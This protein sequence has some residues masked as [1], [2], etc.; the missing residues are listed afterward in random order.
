M[1][2]ESATG[3][4]TA[5]TDMIRAARTARAVEGP[6]LTAMSTAVAIAAAMTSL[7][8]M[9]PRRNQSVLATDTITGAARIAA[10]GA[11]GIEATF[12]VWKLWCRR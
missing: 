12:F 7:T 9:V 1:R 8:L 5:S 10:A 11:G 4:G 3:G 2:D 6:A